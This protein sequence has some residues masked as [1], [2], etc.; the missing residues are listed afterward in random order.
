MV[1][2]YKQ[3]VQLK[4]KTEETVEACAKEI[5]INEIYYDKLKLMMF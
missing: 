3:N 2:S 5:I 1:L 4:Y